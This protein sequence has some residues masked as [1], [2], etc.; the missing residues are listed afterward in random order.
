MRDDFANDVLREA[1]DN[2]FLREFVTA[3]TQQTSKL[4]SV[5]GEQEERLNKLEQQVWSME[6]AHSSV[7][8]RVREVAREQGV[9]KVRH[10]LLDVFI[11]AV[12]F[13]MVGGALA[14]CLLK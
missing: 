14:L 12:S 9:S 7:Q 11:V 6:V 8:S 4:V 10:R 3:L 1:K 2:I 13:V 5:I